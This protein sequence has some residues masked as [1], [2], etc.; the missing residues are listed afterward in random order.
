MFDIHSQEFK[1]VII[2]LIT[3]VILLFL[4]KV[5]MIL[6]P[7]ILGALLAYMFNPFIEMLKHRDFS[8]EGALLIL[9]IIIFNLILLSGLFIFPLMIDELQ[10]LASSIP[11]YIGIVEDS[12]E[13]ILADYE[14]IDLPELVQESI[15]RFLQQ[16]E[17]YIIGIIQRITEYLLNSLF[18]LFSLILAPIITYYLLR[19][20]EQIEHSL[21]NY[22]PALDSPVARGF[23]E[24]VNEVFVGY[25]RG[26]AWVTTL[27]GIFTSFGLYLLGVRFY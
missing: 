17:N 10:S 12:F 1:M 9:I 5:K 3:F 22:L 11:Q 4:L 18:L 21:F 8:R 2:G 19:D 14:R 13:K 25:L 7:F 16:L 27:V 6:L 20:I 24:E 26:Q 15:D 23:R